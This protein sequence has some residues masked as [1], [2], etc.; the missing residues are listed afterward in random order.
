MRM[1]NFALRL[2]TIAVI[3]CVLL[4]C[5]LF[6]RIPSHSPHLHGMAGDSH[7]KSIFDSHYPHGE[8]PMKVWN[9]QQRVR[10]TTPH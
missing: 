5:G 9:G 4:G 1:D 10:P 6:L 2:Q 3:V 7:E 8:N